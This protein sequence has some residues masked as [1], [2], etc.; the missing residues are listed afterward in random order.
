MLKR[1]EVPIRN[2]PGIYKEVRFDDESGKWRDTGKL[3]AIRRIAVNGVSRK[4]QAVFDNIEAAK[5]FRFGLVDKR[6]CGKEVHKNDVTSP[7]VKL[8]FSTL[9]EEWK[10]FHYLQLEPST[11]QTYEKRLP[12]LDFLNAVAV[13]DINLSVVDQL[14]RYWVKEYPKDEQRET[15]EKELNLLKVILNYYRKRKNPSYVIPVFDEH[16]KATDIA[17]KPERAVQSLSQKDLGR[18]LDALKKGI[19]PQ[20]Y[21]L[22]LAQF[23]FGLRIG[24]ACGL[25]WSSLDLENRVATIEQTVVW[26][27]TTWQ[28][29]LKPRPKNKKARILVIPDILIVEYKKLKTRRDPNLDLIFHRNGLPLIRK[30]VG[31]VYNRALQ[32]LEI[33][34][35]SGTHMLRKTSATLANEA[36]GDFYA[37]S[38]LMD[39]STPDITLRY[40]SQ[41]SSQKQKVASALN[42]VLKG[43]L[44]TKTTGASNQ[45]QTDSESGPVPQCPANREPR[46]FRLIKS[47]F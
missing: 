16:Y 18:F 30:D 12:H 14:V 3:R 9:V 26:D 25:T 43:A 40:V 6:S 8:S 24:E 34:H 41:T 46:K 33:T 1:K 32:K 4:E 7:E 42:G 15:F 36:T 45:P 2:N 47:N 23:C 37:V 21:Y 44:E 31:K 27:H 10:T 39:H 22:A 13:E 29:T 19:N 28:P 17:R 5:Q 11:Q 38:K 20:Y 35:V